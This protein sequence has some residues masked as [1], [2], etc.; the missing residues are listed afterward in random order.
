[1]TLKQTLTTNPVKEYYVTEHNETII[2]DSYDDV[3]AQ[4]GHKKVRFIH[5]IQNVCYIKVL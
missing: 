5:T 1:M 3:I 2:L 4:F